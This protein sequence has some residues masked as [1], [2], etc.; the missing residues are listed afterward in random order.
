I[1]STHLMPD[2]ASLSDRVFFID[3]G[4]ILLED[5]LEG[6]KR[7]FT[8]Q[9]IFRVRINTKGMGTEE[10]LKNLLL[11]QEGIEGIAGLS[12]LE[13]SVWE[14]SIKVTSQWNPAPALFSLL[15][16]KGWD[17]V[18]LQQKSVELEE[19]FRQLTSKE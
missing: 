10:Q 12:L 8:D 1:I 7:K 11:S 13:A 6:L 14:V 2:A 9:R 17:L 15:S 18:E 5:S 3:R 16:E 19:V 4:K